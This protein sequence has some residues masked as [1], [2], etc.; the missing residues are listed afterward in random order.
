MRKTQLLPELCIPIITLNL[1]RVMSASLMGPMAR[2]INRFI[3]IYFIVKYVCVLACTYAHNKLAAKL[4]KKIHIYK[5]TDI[6]F[7]FLCIL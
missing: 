5:Y 7:S 1:L 2:I 4:Q 3:A 6:Y